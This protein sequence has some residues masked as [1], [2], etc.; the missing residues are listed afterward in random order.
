MI[1]RSRLGWIVWTV[2]VLALAW[3]VYVDD[4]AAEVVRAV[5]VAVLLGTAAVILDMRWRGD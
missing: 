3:W 4:G 2:A 5:T 1:R